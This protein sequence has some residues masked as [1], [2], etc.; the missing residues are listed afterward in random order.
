MASITPDIPP[1]QYSDNYFCLREAPEL[2]FSSLELTAR[3]A[4][5]KLDRLD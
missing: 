1:T 4:R 2:L 3:A 5:I